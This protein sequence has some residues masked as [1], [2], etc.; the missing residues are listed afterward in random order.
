MKRICQ[1]IICIFL[2]TVIS[3]IGLTYLSNLVRPKDLSYRKTTFIDN[4]SDIDVLF[5][6]TSHMANTI[7]PIEL[8]DEY[9]IPSYN[10]GGHG[11]TLANSYWVMMNVLDYCKPELIVLDCF[12][13]SNEEKSSPDFPH[14]TMDDFPLSQNKVA[15]IFDLYEDLPKRIEYLWD[16]S[17]YHPRWSELTQIDYN[18]P[19]SFQY[20]GEPL[21]SVATPNIPTD[22]NSVIKS[23][24]DTFPKIEK[25][26][27]KKL[28]LKL[29]TYSLNVVAK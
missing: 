7:Y 27:S 24:I 28:S 5:L 20:G 10:M 1:R 3:S 8:W 19:P 26:I 9:G 17:L 2:I 11:H 21:I 12:S 25:N 18:I 6:G 14:W 15:A 16:F 29:T 4:S 13:I 22:V 23:N